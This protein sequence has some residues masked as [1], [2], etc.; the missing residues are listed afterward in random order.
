[1]ELKLV[2]KEIAIQLK[3]L[4]FD[5]KSRSYYENDSLQYLEKDEGSYWNYNEKSRDKYNIC[6]APTQALVRKWFRE[7]HDIHVE[8]NV[9]HSKT[10]DGNKLLYSYSVSSKENHYLG[11]DSNL[12]VWIGLYEI[13]DNKSYHIRETYEEA[14]NDCILEAIEVLKK[15]KENEK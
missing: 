8:V 7:I 3:E 15:R 13:E 2:D 12:D 4:G 10:K 11:I 1:M 14:L 5:W 9:E 6:S